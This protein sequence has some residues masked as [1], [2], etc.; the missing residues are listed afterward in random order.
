MSSC[1]A[2][3]R[4]SP[5]ET[6]K[7]PAIG[8]LYPE[9]K[10]VAEMTAAASADTL[11]TNVLN[12]SD[13]GLLIE[14]PVDFE[15][16]NRFRIMVRFADEEKWRNLEGSVAWTAANPKSTSTFLV[17]IRAQRLPLHEEDLRPPETK[18]AKRMYPR[19]LEFLLQT[20]LFSSLSSEA[21]CSL[22]N[23]MAPERLRAGT[24]LIAQGATG[25]S[26]F[27]IQEG[28]CRVYLAKG[29]RQHDIAM[30]TVG[31]IVGEMSLLTTEPCSANVV[32]GSNMLVWRIG[33]KQVVECY[34][35]YRDLRIFL[36][37]LVTSRY[38]GVEHSANRIIGKYVIQDL[39]GQG[40]WSIVYKG[41]HAELKMPV[42]I[43][44]L[45]HNMALDQDSVETF[46][47]EA[48]IIAQLNHENI[49]KIYDIE[50]CY[51]TVFIIMEFFD[52]VSLAEILA[53][54]HRLPLSNALDILIQ[55]CTGLGF[56][57]EHGIVHQDVKPDNI[58][59]QHD[60]IK[61]FD[62]GLA[63]VP[64]TKD[65]YMPGTVYYM[66]PEQISG[67]PLDE[68][69]DIY[70]TG[71]MAY[72]LVTGAKPF[73]SENIA[74]LLDAQ[75]YREIPDPRKLVPGLPS[76][77]YKILLT[78][79]QKDPNERYRNIWE[80]QWAFREFAKKIGIEDPTVL[81]RQEQM[82]GFMLFY[83]N[84][85]QVKVDKLIEDLANNTAKIGASLRPIDL[86]DE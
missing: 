4:Q 48:K 61:I 11:L 72:E 76:E 28:K 17:G 13:G 44:M 52:G 70:A 24:R 45:K 25:D 14:S 78:A 63:H 50:R 68:R 58:F 8:I 65:D 37:D 27:I 5:R 6:L 41:M 9:E 23:C 79:T 80:L 53:G 30:P 15:V 82:K 55:V 31:D 46:E 42:A 33:I 29:G 83:P 20:I 47:N 26:L 16:Q 35:K 49:V 69:A 62:F 60:R 19:E 73:A 1:G 86:Q 21:K 84:D 3:R 12:R 67:D 74:E 85:L 56:A 2:E 39:I 7:V 34:K 51:E 22:L 40:A 77:F 18:R 59:L 10:T 38:S 54:N 36:T 66:A 71:I 75:Q 43:K 32:S 64:G 57:H 81:S